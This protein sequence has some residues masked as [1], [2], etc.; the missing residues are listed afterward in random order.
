MTA[1]NRREGPAFDAA[2]HAHMARALQLAA[3]GLYGTDPNPRVGCVL[4]RDGRIVG[5]GWHARA[6]AA[7]AEAVALAAAGEAARGATAYVTLEPCAHH[8][9]T[10]P[11]CAA[12][13]A[14]GVAR[15][16]C[17]VQ[18][19]DPRVN[20]RGIAAL[21]EAG[22][23]VESGLLAAEARALNPGFF[24][25]LER[26]RP[27]LRI[28]LGMTLDG[29]TALA[30][31][32]SRWITGEP[33]R[34]DVQRWRARSSAI[35]TGVGT[36][37]A[38][39][40]AL[41]VRA[42]Q[43]AGAVD[44]APPSDRQPL[45]VVLDSRLRTPPT[46]RLLQG[47][48]EALIVTTRADAG[49]AAALRSERVEVVTLPAD[50][51]GRPRLADLMAVLAEGGINEVLVESGPTLAGA[52]WR[53]GLVDE[54]LLYVAPRLFGDSARGAFDL[55]A[56]AGVDEAPALEYIDLRPVGRDLRILARPLP[57]A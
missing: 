47:P 26:G 20:G 8:G 4:V 49:R 31:G 2:D 32:A 13:V 12:L 44:E 42:E 52:F 46:A 54:L 6:G 34:R 10:P 7:H 29:R 21:R 22:V 45:R 56:F 41:T 18:D 50:A 11:C 55:P 53:A 40:P 43:W 57:G 19:P 35:V 14:A 36:V 37:L 28:K 15:V 16:V 1:V 48:G 25:R 39:D 27:W 3:R 33:A 51:D 17:A 9:R 23:R 24:S 5:E 38:D 30:N